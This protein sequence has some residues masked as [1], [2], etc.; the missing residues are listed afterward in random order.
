MTYGTGRCAL[1]TNRDLWDAA[2]ERFACGYN[3][4]EPADDTLL[5]ARVTGEDGR[6]ARDAVQLRLPSD[7]A[8]L[9][10]PAPL[11][12]LHRR[13]ARGAGAARSAP[14]RSSCRARRASSPRATTTSATR[15]SPTATAASSG[16]PPRLRSRAC[17][18][19]ATRFVYTGIVA[20]GANLGTWEY[21]PCDAEQLRASEQLAARVS[22]VELRA[23]GGHRRRRER[24]PTRLP[25]RSQERE[26]ALRRRFLAQ[27][28]GD[29]PVYTM[30]LWI[31]RL[32]ERA[33]R[34]RSATSPTR[35]SRSS[36]GG[37]SRG[38][39]CSCSERRTGRWATCRPRRPT[40][41]GSTRSSSR[42]S[43]PVVSSRR[44]RSPRPRSRSCGARSVVADAAVG[45]VALRQPGVARRAL[46]RLRLVELQAEAGAG[47]RR[48]RSRPRARGAFGKSS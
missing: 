24:S 40:A 5:V 42:R 28:L 14:R 29:G 10:E 27:A 32:G 20:S 48:R 35:S 8:R 22:P 12:R 39:R 25:T 41:P 18:R 47:G 23:Q 36:C 33:A 13:R 15:P 30:P 2:A 17:R 21:Q 6:G 9:G 16:T 45:P 46:A 26:K 37:A 11:A 44:W 31:W 7:D 43:R 3:P 1:A 34:R 19:P 38:R 4:D